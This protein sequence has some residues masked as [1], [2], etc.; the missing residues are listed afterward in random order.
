M[1]N[2][3]LCAMLLLGQMISN[4]PR[5]EYHLQNHRGV[6]LASFGGGT[7]QLMNGPDVVSMPQEPPRLDANN[8]PWTLDVHN[9]GPKDATMI[10]KTRFNAKVKVGQT[11]HIFVK[12]D[13]YAVKH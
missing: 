10:W 9:L 8:Q 12:D 1:T 2:S 4:T 3:L 7:L 11:I 13:G 5:P 6:V